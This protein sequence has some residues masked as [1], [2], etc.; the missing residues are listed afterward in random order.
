MLALKQKGTDDDIVKSL[1][2]KNDL[3]AKPV[4]FCVSPVALGTSN[5]QFNKENFIEI[6]FP[7]FV[8]KSIGSNDEIYVNAAE[9]LE[10]IRKS[11]EVQ[12]NV[13]HASKSS[14]LQT[15]PFN[16]LTDDK[17]SAVHTSGGTLMDIDG[18]KMGNTEHRFG[19]VGISNTIKT[20]EQK[21][22]IT[23]KRESKGSNKRLSHQKASD[24]ISKTDWTGF[25]CNED[26]S[27][28]ESY[29]D[30]SSRKCKFVKSAHHPKCKIEA[31]EPRVNLIQLLQSVED[32][33]P[34]NSVENRIHVPNIGSESG[35][36]NSIVINDIVWAILS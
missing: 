12:G 1:K 26:S 14:F 31:T 10:P 5:S 30:I 27:S 22:I 21:I 20:P 13:H 9:F 34:I 18:S 35:N 6:V 33:Y 16:L 23:P 4:Y 2:R 29:S 28:N 36:D 3:E 25:K 8:D 17:F 32:I 15:K 24:L 19:K 7:N 11:S